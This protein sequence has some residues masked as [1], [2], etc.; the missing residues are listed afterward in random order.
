M[1]RVSRAEGRRGEEGCGAWAC[2]L[3]LTALWLCGRMQDGGGLYFFEGSATL[4]Y[5]SIYGNSAGWVSAALR[6][7]AATALLAHALPLSAAARC[8]SLPLASRLAGRRAFGGSWES[9]LRALRVGSVWAVCCVLGK[10]TGLGAACRRRRG[11][12]LDG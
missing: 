9:G 5:C 3:G 11:A 4:S 10:W 6:F 8:A 1:G 2:G 12:G 7:P